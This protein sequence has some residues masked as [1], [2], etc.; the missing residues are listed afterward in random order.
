MLKSCMPDY[1]FFGRGPNV[2]PKVIMT[3]NGKE[4]KNALTATWPMCILLLCVFHVYG[5][6]GVP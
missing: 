3:D 1:A 2:G 4:E 5:G 6:L